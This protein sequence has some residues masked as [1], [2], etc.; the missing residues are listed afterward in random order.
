MTVPRGPA[1]LSVVALLSLLACDSPDPMQRQ[2]RYEPYRES[3]F[4]AD[5]RMMRPPP[6]DTVPQ[7][8]P[9]GDGPALTGLAN[10]TYVDVLPVPLTR[11]LLE[12]GRERYE[13]VCGACHGVLGDGNTPVAR[14]MALRPPP[15]IA[16]EPAF[17]L[18]A[19]EWSNRD[20]MPDG[21]APSP[22]SQHD[23]PH[24]LGFY[25][26]AISNGFGLMPSY[27]DMLPPEDR[28]AVIAYLRALSRSQRVEASRLP[29]DVREKL[30]GGGR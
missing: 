9:R 22:R 28:W 18:Y 2:P 20:A 13:I 14:N 25:F 5:G 11:A 12:R 29:G 15:A 3:H 7:E 8:K 24:P 27:A 21:G 4:F 30:E 23:L 16:G 1:L 26:D 6:P 17:L 19:R 10:G